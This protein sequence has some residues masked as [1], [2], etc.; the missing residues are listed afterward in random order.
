MKRMKGHRYFFPIIFSLFASFCLGSDLEQWLGRVMRDALETGYGFVTDPLLCQWVERVGKRLGQS[1]GI[2]FQI[3]ILDTEEI[4]AYATIGNFLYVTKGLLRFV[5]SEDELVGVMAHEVTHLVKK[6]AR[7]QMYAIGLSS[8]LSGIKMGEREKKAFMAA[9]LLANLSYSRE[10]EEEADKGAVEL[11]FAS[12]FAPEAFPNFL[13]RLGQGASR[14]G[15][16]FSTH[17]SMQKRL[18]KCEGYLKGMKGKEG[19]YRSLWERGEAKEARDYLRSF[20]NIPIDLSPPPS[21]SPKVSPLPSHLQDKLGA[22]REGLQASYSNLKRVYKWQS[23]FLLAQHYPL[24]PLILQA[25]LQRT[26][27]GEIYEGVGRLYNCV[28]DLG[29]KLIQN[30]K[31]VDLALEKALS[32][33]EEVKKGAGKLE[34]ASAGISTLLLSRHFEEYSLFVLQSLLLSSAK[35]IDTAWRKWRLALISLLPIQLEVLIARLNDMDNDWLRRKCSHR[36][37]TVIEEERLG[38]ACALLAISLSSGQPLEEVRRLRQRITSWQ[39]LAYLVQA[40]MDNICIMLESLN[41]GN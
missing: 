24:L 15:E 40:D 29:L 14:I 35:N 21:F 18:E 7:K 6:H 2:K 9:L 28:N 32:A 19:I 27:L 13:K 8:L 23:L 20:P 38:D 17:P 26:R 22:L 12:G 41:K 39:D 3:Y 36:L 31:G 10:Q 16:F 30:G 33:V 1:A 11:T 5:E 34:V 4:N 25:Y 37:G